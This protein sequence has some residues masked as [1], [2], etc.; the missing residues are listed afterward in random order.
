[1]SDGSSNVGAVYTEL[2]IKAPE[3]LSLQDLIASHQN[4]TPEGALSRDWLR[5]HSEEIPATLIALYAY[6]PFSETQQQLETRILASMTAIHGQTGPRG[7]PEY[8][9]VMQTLPKEED[10]EAA[11]EGSSEDAAFEEDAREAAVPEAAETP[12]SAVTVSIGEEVSSADAPLSS[13]SDHSAAEPS[14]T[15]VSD[16]IANEYDYDSTL[17]VSDD[18]DRDR[19][20]DYAAPPP[21]SVTMSRGGMSGTRPDYVLSSLKRALSNVAHKVEYVPLS[22]EQLDE[23]V[24]DAEG[25]RER[26]KVTMGG[27]F[28]HLFE[29]VQNGAHAYYTSK[30]KRESKIRASLPLAATPIPADKKGK[31]ASAQTATLA[32]LHSNIKGLYYAAFAVSCVWSSVPANIHN[33]IESVVPRGSGS[34]WPWNPPTATLLTE[35]ERER[36]RQSHN[37]GLK[38][39]VA[40]SFD[41]LGQRHRN[42][43]RS[44]SHFS[45]EVNRVQ[46][47]AENI[48][49]YQSSTGV[50]E[51]FLF[52]SCCC[53]LRASAVAASVKLNELLNQATLID[54]DTRIKLVLDGTLLAGQPLIRCIHLTKGLIGLSDPSRTFSHS[55]LHGAVYALLQTGVAK[56][57]HTLANILSSSVLP[58][59][60]QRRIV[61]QTR[62]TKTAGDFTPLEMGRVGLSEMVSMAETLCQGGAGPSMKNSETARHL[63]L[64]YSEAATYY[65]TSLGRLLASAAAY[66]DS[67]DPSQDHS[68]VLAVTPQWSPKWTPTVIGS[69]DSKETTGVQYVGAEDRTA[70]ILVGAVLDA[71]TEEYSHMLDQFQL[72]SASAV[73]MA[74]LT[75]PRTTVPPSTTGSL[76]AAGTTEM[77]FARLSMAR[78]WMHAKVEDHHL[79]SP[80]PEMQCALQELVPLHVSIGCRCT[81]AAGDVAGDELLPSHKDTLAADI[82]VFLAQAPPALSLA[83]HSLDTF[84]LTA[85]RR[86]ALLE[87]LAVVVETKCSAES[88]SV[89]ADRAVSLDTMRSV[90]STAV[91]H[92]YSILSVVALAAARRSPFTLLGNR[93]PAGSAVKLSSAAKESIQHILRIHTSLTG[94]GATAATGSPVS[95]PLVLAPSALPLRLSWAPTESKGSATSTGTSCS[96][97]LCYT[98]DAHL[99]RVMQRVGG[100]DTEGAHILQPSQCGKLHGP[101]VPARGASAM[102]G[103]T[104][105]LSVS[106][107]L[108]GMASLKELLSTPDQPLSASLSVPLSVSMAQWQWSGEEFVQKWRKFT[109][110]NPGMDTPPALT[111]QSTLSLTHLREKEREAEKAAGLTWQT[112]GRVTLEGRVSTIDGE[113][114]SDLS[115]RVLQSLSLT[116]EALSV[117]M[118]S[119]SSATF[120]GCCFRL[121]PSSAP[122]ITFSLP[123]GPVFSMELSGS[124]PAVPS[125]DVLPALAYSTGYLV[126]PSSASAVKGPGSLGASIRGSKR[127]VQPAGSCTSALLS[128][129]VPPIASTISADEDTPSE[130]VSNPPCLLVVAAKSNESAQDVPRVSGSLV[131]EDGS[132]LSLFPEADSSVKFVDT[133]VNPTDSGDIDRLM[134]LRSGATCTV[135]FRAFLVAPHAP[136]FLSLAAN[137]VFIPPFKTSVLQVPGLLSPSLRQDIIKVSNNVAQTLGSPQTPVH[138][139]ATSSRLV[140]PVRYTTKPLGVQLLV[141]LGDETPGTRGVFSYNGKSPYLLP[142][143]GKSKSGLDDSRFVTPT[144]ITSLSAGTAGEEST[145]ANLALVGGE[146]LVSARTMVGTGSDP[147]GK[148][149]VKCDADF[150]KGEGDTEGEDSEKGRESVPPVK[151]QDPRMPYQLQYPFM[152]Q[153]KTPS[154]KPLFDVGYTLPSLRTAAALVG[155][156]HPSLK[157]ECGDEGRIQVLATPHASVDQTPSSKGVERTDVEIGVEFGELP[158]RIHVHDTFTLEVTLTCKGLPAPRQYSMVVDDPSGHL[159][160]SGAKARLVTLTPYTPSYTACI[161]VSPVVQGVIP[162]PVVHVQSIL[163]AADLMLDDEDVEL[164]D[165]MAVEGVAFRTYGAFNQPPRRG[166]GVARSIF[167]I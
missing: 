165:E 34:G 16:P 118:P 19:D 11:V 48:L 40:A 55:S 111:T 3:F 1:M 156:L 12:L 144:E 73:L 91:T 112:V 96:A 164:E 36:M 75:S 8:V 116:R 57:L 83:M 127:F 72:C 100:I 46:G 94:E 88:P 139:E 49:R 54:Q 39:L 66:K 59:C 143:L 95:L 63:W 131:G 117:S 154:P 142:G 148:F 108:P 81:P 101:Q 51:S 151:P 114:D 64:L 79:A 77:L 14:A 97:P 134:L 76:P 145:A 104:V 67:Q 21:P 80:W 121:T 82:R 38:F 41:K 137:F 4:R 99:D 167:V 62:P 103:D 132:R 43:Q 78:H 107:H 93:V 27:A 13:V 136:V 5:K 90:L 158:E 133:L 115:S 84:T 47:T 85:H 157:A 37:R 9:V 28:R 130:P 44:L 98:P 87:R 10:A 74:M 35:R 149:L 138:E 58:L 146:P 7:I 30:L 119:D 56:C 2:S 113:S 161:H 155:A 20:Q 17:M 6:D 31:D 105:S 24:G 15:S 152:P 125:L 92:V 86:V 89:D 32:H 150:F 70:G 147:V 71:D 52:L 60:D 26:D 159:R 141:S 23:L 68:R 33:Q 162:L 102:T 140:D 160:V 166:E 110:I 163:P 126:S 29:S 25:E 123:S 42:L 109:P 61:D 45:I 50:F 124:Q 22:A 65:K 153:S 120:P 129:C 69:Q 106:G 53:L 122:V 18:L 128:L 135:G